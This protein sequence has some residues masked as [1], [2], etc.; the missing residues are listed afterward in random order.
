MKRATCLLIVL[1]TVAGHTAAQDISFIKDTLIFQDNF[2]TADSSNWII[3]KK[4]SPNEIAGRKNGKLLFDTYGGV[5]A[6]YAKELGG[7]YYISFKRTI[8]ID[9]GKNDRLSD[10]NVFWMAT[11]PRHN[12]SFNRRGDFSEYDSLRMYYIGMGGNYNTTTRFRRYDGKGEKKII[13]EYTDSLHL[14][15]ANKEYLF[16]IIVKDGQTVFKAD[17]QIFFSFKD[18]QPLTR[19]WFAIRSTRSRQE[20]DDV[21]IWRIR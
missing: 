2:N 4:H 7:N 6:W 18:T 20:I 16:E 21:E 19:G 5:T 3:E 1:M 13:G 9:G 14:L 10:C 11:D 8:I 15:K 12:L 17:G